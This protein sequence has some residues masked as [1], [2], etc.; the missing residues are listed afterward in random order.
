MASKVTAGSAN[1]TGL[2][3]LLATC[4]PIVGLAWVGKQPAVPR[5]TIQ[6]HGRADGA[7]GGR[8]R[9]QLQIDDRIG[10]GAGTRPLMANE[11]LLL[12]VWRYGNRV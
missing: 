9:Q 12:A 11:G 8:G 5:R 1:R 3:D 10:G 6:F 2:D 7:R 4:A